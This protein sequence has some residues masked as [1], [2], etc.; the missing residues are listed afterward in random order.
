MLLHGRAVCDSWLEKL[1]SASQINRAEHSNFLNLYIGALCYWQ[2]D[3]DVS[4]C[5]LGTMSLSRLPF[6]VFLVFFF[7]PLEPFFLLLGLVKWVKCF[8]SCC[9]NFYEIWYC[10]SSSP[11]RWS[12]NYLR[13][14]LTALH[15]KVLTSSARF[16]YGAA[17]MRPILW[18][19]HWHNLLW[20]HKC[21]PLKAWGF[22]CIIAAYCHQRKETMTHSGELN[23]TCSESFYSKDVPWIVTI[24]AVITSKQPKM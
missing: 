17:V 12:W 15:F 5:I 2:H 18:E 1:C 19:W 10:F 4:C 9:I 6:N 8:T 20:C 11:G 7:H 13:M 14:H 21:R 23:R 22:T 3:Y 24:F 16:P